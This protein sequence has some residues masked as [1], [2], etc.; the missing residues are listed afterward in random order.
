MVKKSILIICRNNLSKAPRFLMEVD[1]LSSDYNI[2]AAGLSTEVGNNYMFLPLQIPLEKGKGNIN[3]HFNYPVYIRKIISS[4]IRIVYYKYIHA[5]EIASKKEFKTL[6]KFEYQIVIV[7]HFVDLPL[8]VKLAKSKKVKLI[9]NAHEYYPLEFDNDTNW[10]NST[11]LNYMKIANK[12]LK[13]VDICFCVANLIAIKYNQE[14]NLKSEVITNAKLFHDLKPSVIIAGNKIKLIHHGVALRNRQIE[15]MINMMSYLSDHFTLDLILV[16]GDLEYIAELRE[17]SKK[18]INISF[19]DIMPTSQ[20][21]EALNKYDIGVYILP[22]NNFN[23]KNALPNKFFE[24]I[25]A[26]LAIAISPSPEMAMLVNKYD[27]GV[28]ADNFTG[29]SLAE[30]IKELSI[31][32]IMYFKNNCNQHAVDLCVEKNWELIKGTVKTLIS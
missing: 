3:F 16:P 14:F 19:K 24:F 22:P 5:D 32:K 6:S 30:K 13:H 7:H 25:Q 28:V 31:E 15:L 27:L 2:F 26:R 21:I 29:E 17:L 18:Y 11:H 23:D 20:I 4:L 1:A 9:F 10:M 8:A 12:Y